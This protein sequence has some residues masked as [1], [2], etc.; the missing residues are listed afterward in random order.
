M[1][2]LAARL[3]NRTIGVNS[4]RLGVASS[5][6]MVTGRVTIRHSTL[7]IQALVERQPSATRLLWVKE[8]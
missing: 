7:Q 3:P 6:F 4:S 1:A 5:Y 2:D 8:I